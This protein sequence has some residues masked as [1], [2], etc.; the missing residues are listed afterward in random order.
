MALIEK[1]DLNSQPK[2]PVQDLELDLSGGFSLC[3]CCNEPLHSIDKQDVADLLPPYV[4][5]TQAKFFE[6]PGCR[7]VCWPRIHWANMK[8]ELSQVSQE[9]L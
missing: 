7:R 9:A 2:Q 6:C 3:V 1:D 4:L 5:L 8:S